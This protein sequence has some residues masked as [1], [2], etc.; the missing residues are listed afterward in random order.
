MNVH[1]TTDDE[2]LE[3]MTQYFCGFWIFKKK[4]VVTINQIDVEEDREG[5]GKKSSPLL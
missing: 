4:N 1:C 5:K 3:S 2:L